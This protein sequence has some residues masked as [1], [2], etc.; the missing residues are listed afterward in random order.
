M[1]GVLDVANLSILV[2]GKT[3]H[4]PLIVDDVSFTVGKGEIVGLV[5]ESGSGKTT[6]ARGILGLVKPSA[7]KI[8]GPATSIS[9]FSEKNFRALRSKIAL[10]FQNPAA[11]FNARMRVAA[12][13]TEGRQGADAAALLTLVGL[14]ADF[15]T[16]YP[17]ELSGGQ[18]RRVAVARALA[19]NPALIIAD[20][21][22]AGLDVSVQGEILN[23]LL[24]LRDQTCLSVLLITHNLPVIRHVSDRLVV[25][26][27]GRVV[28]S[29]STSQIF[30][31]PAHPYTR[32]LIDAEP[33]PDP[34]I[35]QTGPATTGEA[36]SLFARPTGCGFHPR[37]PRAAP[38][39][40]TEA[41]ALRDIG[42][43]HAVRCHDPLLQHA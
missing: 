18:A 30:R 3:R 7:G 40:H 39:C 28:E 27:L 5:G 29:G 42:P 4:A 14:P 35:P 2:P 13:I 38:R 21:P 32:A 34:S 26:Y 12:I 1:S 8:N 41:P 43:M 23:L 33:N 16:R 25:L 37:C 22:T 15:R 6:L 31:S 9:V 11:S 10:L 24:D 36:P 19:S 20:E 17:H